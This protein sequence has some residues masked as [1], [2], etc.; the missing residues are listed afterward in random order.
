ME[1]R[2]Q[3]DEGCRLVWAV[4]RLAWVVRRHR[5]VGLE[6]SRRRVA[7]LVAC[8][9]VGGVDRRRE[10]RLRDSSRRLGLVGRAEA[11][12]VDR[13]ALAGVEMRAA[14][15]GGTNDYRA[16]ASWRMAAATH[17]SV[18]SSRETRG[19]GGRRE[20]SM[21]Q[22]QKMTCDAAGVRWL[23]CAL[24][25]ETTNKVSFGRVLSTAP[26]SIRGMEGIDTQTGRDSSARPVVESWMSS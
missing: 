3:R 11:S 13:L 19:F 6:G 22:V 1:S 18:T 16:Q 8:R 15:S 24:V 5:V 4:R 7:C 12:R 25:E 20:F 21:E 9:L 26:T 2:D 14:P 23:T 17:V 10:D